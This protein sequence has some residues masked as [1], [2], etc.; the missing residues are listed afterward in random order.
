[1]DR[2]TIVLGLGNPLMGDDGAGL[3][4]LEALRLGYDF[5]AGVSL[6]DGGTLG[7]ALLPLVEDAGSLLVL[8]AVRLGGR[9]GTTVVREGDEIPR[10]LSLKLSPHQTGFRE[11]LALAGLRGNLPPRLAL[12]GVEVANAEYARPLSLEVQNALPAMV[13]AAV[14]RL[15]AWG[16]TL[17]PIAPQRFQNLSRGLAAT[18]H[19]DTPAQV[20]SRQL[21]P[22]ATR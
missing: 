21:L 5:G 19:A 15:E 14:A 22:S 8:D 20:D 16:C 11:T 12:V 9:T 18:S 13:A 1:V 4:A 10:C 2:P 7:L 6:E 3:A 17:R